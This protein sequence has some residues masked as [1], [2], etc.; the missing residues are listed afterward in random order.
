[1]G[2]RFFRLLAIALTGIFL[3]A[4]LAACGGGGESSAPTT[5]GGD[6]VGDGQYLLTVDGYGV[7]EEEFVQFLADQKAITTNYFWTNYQRQG[8]PDYWS[9]EVDGQTPLDYAKR[10]AL[11]ALVKSKTEF[12][13]AA[14]RDILAY[15]DYDGL[16][17]NMEAEN[18][19]RAKKLENGEVFYGLTEFTPFTYYQYLNTN[20]R[21]ELEQSQQKLSKPTEADLRRVYDE[22]LES[23]TL[24][25]VYIY[26]V[27][28]ADGTSETITQN[29]LEIGKADETTEILLDV[30]DTMTPGSAIDAFDYHGV[31]A[32]ITFQS[33]TPQGYASFEDMK[34]SLHAL[35]ARSE[36]SALVQARA[37]AAEVVFDQARF[38][39]VQMP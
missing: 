4:S 24:G 14:E 19:D 23:F 30:F 26:D 5:R 2:A 39:A 31:T 11:E 10:R 36:L 15:K 38:D 35:Y 34:E 9:T 1:M 37:K 6:T 18:A 3:T 27:T 7:T 21:S 17:T 33:K 28:Y 16:M 25:D 20:L 22:N 29:S 8:S 32:K 12:I 13:L